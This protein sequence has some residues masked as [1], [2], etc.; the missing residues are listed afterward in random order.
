MAQTNVDGAVV[1]RAGGKGSVSVT[2]SATGVT[3]TTSVAADGSF[4]VGSLPP[5]AY[6]VTYTPA[7]GAALEQLVDVRLGSSTPVDFSGNTAVK[8]EKFV[9]AG[10]Q[11]S[12][13]DFS[14]TESATLFSDKLVKELPVGRSTTAV[15]LLTPGTTQG[16][17]SFGG[18]SISG[19]SVAEN[20]YYVN[21][22]NLS[23]FRNGLPSTTV[24]FE[25]YEQFEIKN[26]AYA[27]DYGRSTGGV[28]NGAT[29]RGTN[30][31]K[32]GLNVYFTPDRLRWK[33]PDS[34]YQDSTGKTQVYRYTGK[35]WAQ[36]ADA[37]V[38]ASGP[39]LKDKVFFFGLY[40]AADLRSKGAG[41]TTYAETR[42]D[43]PFWGG[44]LDI[45][46]LKGHHLEVTAFSDKQDSVTDTYRF[47][48]AT[49]TIGTLRDT[50]T[51]ST[52]G[53]N[54]IYRY[55]GNF[56]D[57]LTF[58][59]LYGRNTY[60]QTT[61]SNVDTQPL[62]IDGRT[63]F[64]VTQHTGSSSF[65]E[66]GAD[67]RKAWRA[68][69]EYTFKLA[70]SHRLRAG[71]DYELNTQQTIQ[72]YSGG[73]YWRYVSVVPGYAMPAGGVAV[74]E[75]IYRNGG[76]LD[77]K[78]NAWYLEDNWSLLNDRLLVRA[79]IRDEGF[80]NFN[81][82]GEPFVKIAH[83]WAPRLGAAYDL[84]GDTRTKV[85]ANFGR[86]MLPIASNT[87]Y[88]L[89]G[90]ELYTQDYYL[91]NSI[92]SDWKPSKGAK[93]GNSTVFADGSIPDPA[94]IVDQ[95]LKSMYQDEYVIGFQHALNKSW[96]VGMKAIHRDLRTSIDD[97]IADYG[98]GKWAKQ[99]NKT[100]V[101]GA[102]AYVL[103]NPG[104]DVSFKFDVDGDG[105][106][107]NVNLTAADIGMPAAV[108]KYF[109]LEFNAER[110]WDKK[111]RAQFSYTW[112]HSYGN[113]EGWVKS[114]N[115][116][117]D[118]GL[119]SSFDS[120]GLMEGSYGN[121]PNDRRHQFKAFGSYVLTKEILLGL[122]FRYSSGRPKNI[123]SY[124][125]TES[126]AQ[127]YG[128]E[129]FY[130]PSGKLRP[131]GSLGFTPW[132]FYNDFSL[133]YRPKWGREKIGF[134]AYV[135]NVMNFHTKTEIVEQATV[136]SGQTPTG[137]FGMPAALQSPRSIRL[138][139]SFDF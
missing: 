71:Y 89:A 123:F 88:R 139:M 121:L 31:Y 16:D 119:T 52:G 40:Q 83:Q 104:K 128:A 74:R 82:K 106:L 14:K 1:G 135:T 114:D 136:A 5:G 34:S 42:N 131:R 62:V 105:K 7:S 132:V 127:G 11:F 115:G 19:S 37:N 110:M 29:K 99:N 111:W 69:L 36:S 27:A 51:S 28:I 22:F 44:K 24:P 43:S 58:S 30:E 122:N 93:V 20:A 67:S 129:S 61:L 65:V 120:V 13:I 84:K 117:D 48:F 2:A 116:Q 17:T 3:R 38:Y 53:T 108:R 64:P 68:D 112:S 66:T 75:R 35:T 26:E 6:K 59:A 109:A 46:P 118:A 49:K 60:N 87:N 137:A 138:N 55:T 57:N 72:A 56:T 130:D 25:F 9:V 23:N 70:G 8:L 85:F 125:P 95:N 39:I 101:P 113:S 73:I 94:T 10:A 4:R 41:A 77:V 90:G 107:E 103:A 92:G 45:H 78:N 100:L 96:T 76:S 18:V 21:G 50:V 63:G 80:E 79:G 12:P 134:N 86:Y 32:A 15:A 54:Q 81:S 124:H 98:L 102:H 91:V 126:T 97:L 33:N 47:D 133:T